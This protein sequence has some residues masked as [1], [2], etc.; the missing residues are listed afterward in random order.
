M[1]HPTRI[2]ALAIVALV[3]PAGASASPRATVAP[4]GAS[5]ITQYL[6]VVPSATGARPPG[7]G[8]G[9][10]GVLT[11]AARGRLGRYGPAGRTLAAVV[12]ATAPPSV[13][14][15]AGVPRSLSGPPAGSA[16]A[17]GSG[18]DA[19]RPLPSRSVGSP[20]SLMLDAAG[21]GGSGGLGLL[22]PTFMLTSALGAGVYAVRRRM[23]S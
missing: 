23:H 3:L 1:R 8:G 7:A 18:V 5:G 13:G 17:G 16:R 2:I 14:D 9:S 11:E 21:G 20:A 6:E 15:A 4:P 22:L 12:D 19:S 10:G